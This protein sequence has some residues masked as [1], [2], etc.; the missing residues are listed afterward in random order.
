[1]KHRDNIP[2][3]ASV[4]RF[5]RDA[6][7]P[8]IELRSIEDGRQVCYGRHAHEI[9][10]IGA[11]SHGQ[12]TY[13]NRDVDQR[14]S[15]GTVVLMNPGDVHACNPIDG[16]PWSYLMLYVD[17]Q[18]LG[19]LQHARGLADTPSFQRFACIAS[20]DAE[21]YGG[22]LRLRDTLFDPACGPGDKAAQA[23]AFFTLALE[24]LTL[25]GDNGDSINPR[26]EQA[27]R[28]IHRHC[29][30]TLSLDTLCE[31]AQLSPSQLIRGFKR[32]YGMTPHA[33]LLN[34]RIQFAH[35][36]LKSGAPLAEV[37]LEAG[38]ADQAH[39]QRTFKQFL[40]ATPGQY[41]G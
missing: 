9:F 41:R 33:Y 27:A 31:A 11:I 14:V 20:E 38:F 30:A 1:M 16:E 29:G 35:A 25:E 10:S 34:R 2:K 26:L 23:T 37:A 21:L 28:L 13:S 39:F 24:R 8:F 40:A 17:P 18:W 6:A 7:L 12:S 15:Q 3:Q 4:P 32:R 19:R 22:L 5:W 36:R